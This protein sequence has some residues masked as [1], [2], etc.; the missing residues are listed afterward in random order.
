MSNKTIRY[1]AVFN[2]KNKLNKNGTGLIQIEA[3]KDATRVYFSTGIYIKPL[4]WSIEK[5][6]V[7]KHKEAAAHNNRIA[8]I[9]EQC[10]DIEFK[11]NRGK[12]DFSVFDLKQEMEN[13]LN[14]SFITFA[15][16]QLD[17]ET[18]LSSGTR[19]KYKKAI[20]TFKE[21]AQNDITFAKL[22]NKLLDDF[23]FHLIKKGLIPNTRKL[24]F[25]TISKYANLA[26]RYNMLEYNK[27]PFPDKKNNQG[28][29]NQVQPKRG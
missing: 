1:T 22:N 29:N 9:I 24:Y 3:Y 8:E 10:K 13:T 2:R 25:K 11:K 14:D 27:N 28:E 18:N 15:L 4:H 19:I 20:N 23:D 6:Q 5:A 7:I 17:K 16:K 26:V 12:I 21:F